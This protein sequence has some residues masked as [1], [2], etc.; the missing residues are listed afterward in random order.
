MTTLEES[1][2]KLKQQ[3]KTERW[4]LEQ[5]KRRDHRYGEQQRNNGF[6]INDEVPVELVDRN[7][8]GRELEL[9]HD[10]DD[11]GEFE[12]ATISTTATEHMS[13]LSATIA[14]TDEPTVV[15][16]VSSRCTK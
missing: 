12:A 9:D 7:A 11:Q 8:T 2:L 10:D 14:A 13:G 6:R 1:L 4:A 15:P 5:Q 3:K 16:N